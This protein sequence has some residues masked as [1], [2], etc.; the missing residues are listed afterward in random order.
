MDVC[1]SLDIVPAKVLAKDYLASLKKTQGKKG[2][3]IEID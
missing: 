1:L 2:E 3:A